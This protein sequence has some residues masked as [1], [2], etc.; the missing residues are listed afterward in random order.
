MKTN[1]VRPIASRLGK[2][3]AAGL[4]TAALALMP[5]TAMAVEASEAEQAPV[6]EAVDAGAP[7]QDEEAVGDAQAAG[8]EEIASGAALPGVGELSGEAGQEAQAAASEQPPAPSDAV[9]GE[10][11]YTMTFY[12]C[13]VVY[14]D[15]PNFDHPSNLRVL[16]TQVVEGLHEGDVLNT[17]DYVK[18]IEGFTFFDA[19]PAKPVVTTDNEANGVQLHYMRSN[20]EDCTVNYYAL[21]DGED[22]GE[23]TLEID[24]KT[25]G[26]DRMGSFQIEDQFFGQ[27]MSGAQMAVPIEDMTYVDSYPSSIQLTTNPDENVL[28][29]FYVAE[30]SLPDATPGPGEVKP[31]SAAVDGPASST[32]PMTSPVQQA[33][34]AAEGPEGST[35]L[36]QTGDDATALVALLLVTTGLAALGVAF[37]T[38]RHGRGDP[39]RMS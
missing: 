5:L 38:R 39:R 17:W 23:G 18:Y 9:D 16:G 36:A 26:F 30:A 1:T 24:G 29:L 3:M 11:T 7:A 22:P 34:M 32:S 14:Y 37:A 15:D 13:E 10:A 28:N 12:Y 25:V 27:E 19:W 31:P 33:S 35:G 2:R 6:P 21:T 20:Q 8:F 4:L